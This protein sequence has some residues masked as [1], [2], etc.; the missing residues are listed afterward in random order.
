MKE[1]KKS[2]LSMK[3]IVRC[4]PRLAQVATTTAVQRN[5]SNAETPRE[6]H[7]TKES[8]I[9]GQSAVASAVI[10]KYSGSS[11]RSVDMSAI[12]VL[13]VLA[14]CVLPV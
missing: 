1:E 8:S 4:C 5:D 6:R 3:N 10:K 2:A 14:W 11:F 12:Y 7:T 13:A 9:F